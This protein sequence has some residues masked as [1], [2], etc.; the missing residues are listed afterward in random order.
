[1]C[2]FAR[3]EVE[4]KTSVFLGK[5]SGID[6]YQWSGSNMLLRSHL[7]RISEMPA[8]MKASYQVLVPSCFPSK[9]VPGNL[10]F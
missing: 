9:Q 10:C 5:E 3:H 7:R 6:L 8:G 4:G 2:S 1:M